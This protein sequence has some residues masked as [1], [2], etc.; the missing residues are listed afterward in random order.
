MNLRL[1]KAKRSGRLFYRTMMTKKWWL[2]VMC[3][4]LLFIIG[5]C[6]AVMLT[7][8][9]YDLDSLKK[10]RFATTLYDHDDKAVVT[11]GD[12]KKEYVDLNKVKSQELIESFVAVEDERFYQHNGAD[13][14]G[15]G[16]AIAIDILTLSPKQGASTITQQ[17]SRNIILNE[18]KKTFLRKVN[19]IAISYNLERKY[20]KREI[21]QA[22]LNYVYL[23]NDC[24]GI[25]MAAK[26]YFNKDITKE[27][28]KPNEIALLA[29]LPKAPEGYNPYIHPDEAKFRRNVVLNK[30]A[31]HKI[32]TKDEAEK[33]KQTKLGVNK[34]Y[35]QNSKSDGRFQA[36]KDYLLREAE[37]R[38]GLDSKELVNGGFKIY[39]GMNK[40]AQLSLERALKDS[41]F[42]KGHDKLNA[43]STMIDPKTGSIAALGGGRSYIRGYLNQALAPAQPGSSIKPLTVYAPAVEEKGYN[44]YSPVSDAPFSYRGW[45]PKN[46]DH[47]YHGNLALQDVAAKSLNVATARLLV[48]RV[49]VNT[50]F[51]YANKLGLHLQSSDKSP[52]PLALGGLTKG[53]STLQMAQAYSVFPNKG[54]MTEAH[55]IQKIVD[56]DGNVVEPKDAIK[57]NQHIFKSS[58]ASTMNNVLKHVVTAGSGRNAALSDGRDVAGKT[59][60]TQ[61]SKEAWFVGYTKEYV[62]ATIVFNERGSRVDLTGGEYPARIFHEVMGE[63]LSGTKVSQ[64]NSEGAKSTPSD[65]NNDGWNTYFG[66]QS[67]EPDQPADQPSN[68]PS[69]QGNE[70]SD[71]ASQGGEPSTPPQRPG[72]GD[73]NQGG[74]QPDDPGDGAGGQDQGAD[75]PEGDQGD[76]PPTNPNDPPNDTNP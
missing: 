25:K 57:K 9:Y 44:Q 60:T 18:N 16:R 73:N 17:V 74:D 56:V 10:L 35:L 66:D 19:E 14:K 50:A 33:Y 6:A 70:P 40:K 41:T 31:E 62:M 11:M 22:Y 59:G 54:K 28:L 48:D 49:G 23:G 4:S 75:N 39:T 32:I 72:G 38:Y 34:K 67:D 20:S 47:M 3:T 1:R 68:P 53:V 21:L 12:S 64:L 58:T 61:N 55:T 43:G 71:S 65:N 8:A 76:P 52:A 69:D 63:T 27:K 5:G 26:I 37:E 30:M 46:M 24:R 13:L 2:L 45:S 7:T 36:Y 29:G 42:Y 51:Q 15:I